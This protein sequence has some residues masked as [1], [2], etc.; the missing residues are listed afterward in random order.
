MPTL[1][2]TKIFSFAASHFLTKYHGKCENLHG[3]NYT[4]EVS[5]LG[6]MREDD[7]VY[8]F[9]ELK[10]VVK[11]KIISELDHHHLNDRFENPSAEVIAV[12]IWE[13]LEQDLHLFEIKLWETSTCF[14]SY[15]GHSGF[16]PHLPL[17][18]SS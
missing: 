13:Q 5:V 8:D 2:V 14:V 7:L 4:L 10:K 1:T 16:L 15:R 6:E 11:R 3:H 18:L 9:V 17:D 12:W